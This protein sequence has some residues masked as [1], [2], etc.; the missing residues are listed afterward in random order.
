MARSRRISFLKYRTPLHSF[1]VEL[2]FFDVYILR[3]RRAYKR[4]HTRLGV[5]IHGAGALGQHLKANFL[6]YDRKLKL[7]AVP[8]RHP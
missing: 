4:G 5:G 3:L 7:Y 1:N 8:F 2:P 6:L